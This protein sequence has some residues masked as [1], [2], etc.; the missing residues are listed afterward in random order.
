MT[1]ARLL[2][3]CLLL[4]FLLGACAPAAEPPSLPTSSPEAAEGLYLNLVWHQHQPLYYQEP[5]GVYTRPWVRVHATKDYYDMA[6]TVAQYPEVHVTFNLTPVL[7]RQLED[8]ADGGA[9]DAY[10]VLAEK[11]AASL[12]EDDKRFLLTR[13]FDANYANLIGRFPRYQELLNQRGGATE[14]EIDRALATF[15]ESDYQDLQVWFNLAWFD[16]DFLAQP[17]LQSLVEKGEAFSEEDKVVLFEEARRIIREVIPLHRQLQDAGQIEVITTPYAHPILPLLYNTKLALIG[18][19]DAEM[20]ERF[21]YP[22]DAIAQLEIAAEKY[23]ERFGREPGGLWPAEGA[24]AEDII[25]LVANAGFRWMASGEQV[26]AHSLGIGAFT[27]NASD[28]VQEADALYRPYFVQGDRGDPVLIVFRD[29]RLSDLIGFEYSQTPGEEAAAD[30]LQRLEDIRQQLDAEGAQGPHLVSVILD[31]ENAWEYYPND[32][33]AFLNAL[34]QGLS[35]STTIRTVTPSEYLEMFPE[36]RTLETLFPG[37]WFSPNFDTWIGEPEETRAWEYLLETR[38]DLAKYDLTQD[39][40]PP[41]PQALAEALDFLYLAEGSDWLWWYGADQNSGND[42]YF[43]RGFRALLAGV[44]ESLGEEVPA[45]VR[46]PILASAPAPATQG[47]KA[48]FTPT[49]DGRLSPETEWDQAAVYSAAG[50]VQARSDDLASSLSLTVDANNLYL[51]IAVDPGLWSLAEPG[52]SLYLASSRLKSANPFRASPD[53]AGELRP[54]GFPATTL[55]QL[56]LQQP[57]PGVTWSSPVGEQWRPTPEGSSIRAA[58]GEGGVEIAVPLTLLG[59]PEPGDDLQ[60]L[61]EITD[62]TRSLQDLPGQGPASLMLPDLGQAEILLQIADPAGDDHGPGTYTYPTDSVFE[63]QVFDLKSFT[64]AADERNLTFTFDLYGPLTNPWGS[65]NNLALQTLDVYVDQD[66]G[67]GTGARLLLPGRNA[68]LAEGFG[69]EAAVWAEGWT[70]QFL[71]PDASGA[72]IQDSKVSFKVISDVAAQKVSLRVPRAAFGE[73]NPATWAYVAV[74]LSQDGFPSPGVWRVR[75][76]EPQ[77][78]QWRMGGGP[79]D[80][81]HTRIVDLAWPEGAGVTQ[82]QM[83][84]AYPGSTQPVDSLEP[85]L[86]ALLTMLQP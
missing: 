79:N 7:L 84:S 78:A 40:V 85:D 86:F 31:G 60:L 34:Y 80:T 24:V 36:Q 28:T 72:P 69:W 13:F 45:F 43:D 10:W 63:P 12:T 3:L 35:E 20:P 61:L 58:A 74:L 16:P 76:V 57:A 67:Q 49:V 44:Y 41:S 9:K 4:S 30:F 11:P 54:I 6:S 27:R 8:F 50:G 55:L 48:P 46:V 82:E 64:V 18:N 70:P 51:R 33:K 37:A 19:P 56:D 53:A 66:P 71:R 38:K 47:L 52:L 25:P 59:E 65:P 22:N 62:G 23:R 5:A 73:G 77:A 29:L 15:D 1:P 81:N 39:Q 2:S 26:L 17:P 68:A 21:S 83:L 32:G 42:D 14:A 75:D